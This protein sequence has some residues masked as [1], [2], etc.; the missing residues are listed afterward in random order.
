MGNKTTSSLESG[1]PMIVPPSHLKLELIS[2]GSY[3]SMSICAGFILSF[4]QVLIYDLHCSK[5]DDL[6]VNEIILVVANL[7]DC[8]DIEHG[9]V[10]EMIV[11]AA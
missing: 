4:S 1:Q 6:D 11:L 8:H 5:T 9:D 3:S 10:Y 7:D 2:T